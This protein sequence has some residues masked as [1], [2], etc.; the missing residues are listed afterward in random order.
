MLYV[1]DAAR[2][3]SN[4]QQE[5]SFKPDIVIERPTFSIDEFT[6]ISELRIS[7]LREFESLIASLRL[8]KRSFNLKLFLMK[9]MY[10][11]KIQKS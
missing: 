4:I 5:A 11:T 6:E 3:Y 8:T 9:Q 1:H 7:S 2:S 10:L